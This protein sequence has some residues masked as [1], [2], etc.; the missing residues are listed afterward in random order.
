MCSFYMSNINAN[1]I[2]SNNIATTNLN[3]TNI[4]GVP[5]ANLI[6]GYYPCQSCNAP[7]CDPDIGCGEC[8]GCADF[9]PDACDCYIAPSGGATG[10][11][12]PAGPT[13]IATYW[14]DYLYWNNLTSAW[15]VGDENITLGRNAGQT[16]QG[17]NAV[18]LGF[19]AGNNNQGTQAVA[20]GYQA[21]QNTQ[22][23]RAVSIGYNAGQES[24]QTN[25]VAIGRESG[26]TYQGQSAVAIGYLAGQ[27]TQGQNAVAIGSI[28]GRQYQTDYAIAIGS[29]AAELGQGLNSIAIGRG[30]GNQTQNQQAIAI[31]TSA[32]S[33]LQASHAI[34][35]GTSAGSLSQGGFS[36][37]IGYQA[38]QTQQASGAI[39]IGYRAGQTN[40]PA[41]SIVVNA[42]FTALSGVTQS[43]FYVAPIRAATQSTALGY[44][45]TNKEITYYTPSPSPAS[46]IDITETDSGTYYPT[47]V[48]A[49]GSGQTLRADT[50]LPPLQF[51]LSANL[52]QILTFT[53][54]VTTSQVLK[55]LAL[56]TG[57]GNQGSTIELS[58]G[59]NAGNGA[60]ITLLADNTDSSIFSTLIMNSNQFWGRYSYNDGGG[61]SATY[62]AGFRSN[63]YAVNQVRSCM[64]SDDGTGVGTAGIRVA[65]SNSIDMFING[66]NFTDSAA[67]IASFNSGGQILFYRP[68]TFDG[69]NGVLEKSIAQTLTGTTVFT[70]A[71]RFLTTIISTTAPRTIQ[72][73]AL[74]AGSNVGYWYGICNK[75][76]FALTIQTSTGTTIASIAG[77]VAGSAGNSARFAVDSAGTSYFSPMQ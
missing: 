4:N 71:N 62:T 64:Y 51:T 36:V 66:I 47:F 7:D 31:G 52:K 15:V 27:G 55:L 25:A 32:G 69:N 59:F 58:S 45:V 40:Q 16:S 70:T 41:N 37:A 3:V 53:N 54:S 42:Q 24:Q 33:R 19:F 49:S 26:L 29:S 5:I 76:L 23:Y 21:G 68:L 9:V 28:A 57:I 10:A 13:P 48:S 6:G 39:A 1:N 35:I 65:N 60:Q 8:N 63:L 50:V 43:S 72:L 30:S 34:A 38:A 77:V 12:G 17:T 74:V 20:I 56:N 22:G 61:E 44:D 14:A 2:T 11:T 18:A 46:T 67:N 75:S 73:P